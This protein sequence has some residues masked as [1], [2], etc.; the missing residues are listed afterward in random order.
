MSEHARRE[1]GAKRNDRKGSI[2]IV[3]VIYFILRVIYVVRGS[4][5]GGGGCGISENVSAQSGGGGNVGKRVT[6]GGRS[7]G[8]I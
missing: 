6:D 3:Q 4:D 8:E 1:R 5:G 2:E 7:K